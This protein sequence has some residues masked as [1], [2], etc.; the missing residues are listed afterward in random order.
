MFLT[1]REVADLIRKSLSYVQ[2]LRS[3]GGGPRYLKIGASIRYRRA[4]VDAWL[5][6][7]ERTRVWEF[8]NKDTFE[9]VGDAATRVVKK[10]SK[11]RR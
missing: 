2:H 4:D 11:R 1:E 5:A 9:P 3:D 6:E 7:L 8:D 10:L